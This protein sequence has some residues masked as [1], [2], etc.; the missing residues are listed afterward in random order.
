MTEIIT[1]PAEPVVKP[2]VPV[3]QIPEPVVKGKEENT[4]TFE[5][6]QKLLDE[7]KKVEAKLK[8]FEDEKVKSEKVKLEKDGEYQKLL[9]ME[10]K[11]NDNLRESLK[12]KEL[13]LLASDFHD[14][15]DILSHYNRF[16]FDDEMN[17]TNSD[18]ILADLKEKKPYLFRGESDP[19]IKTMTTAPTGFKTGHK[20][21]ELEISRMSPEMYEKNS[22]VILQQMEENGG[23]LN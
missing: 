8:K 20:F 23:K 13:K 17:I 11:N 21:S 15:A 9:D 6:H 2:A 18:E 12:K 1:K 14:P 16:E 22:D 7:K 3:E 10:K 19:K 5:S 4:V